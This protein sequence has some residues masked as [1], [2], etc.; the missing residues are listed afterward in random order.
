MDTG[1]NP[2]FDG[3]PIFRTG[4]EITEKER[5]NWAKTGPDGD[6]PGEGVSFFLGV[7]VEAE[8]RKSA[9]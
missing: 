3:W 1:L 8:K 5:E 4:S 7:L 9:W 6:P 2:L